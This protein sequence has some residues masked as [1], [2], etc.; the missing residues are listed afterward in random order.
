MLDMINRHRAE[1]RESLSDEENSPV[2]DFSIS[3]LIAAAINS[4]R[5]KT[6]RTSV[7]VLSNVNKTVEVLLYTS[8]AVVFLERVSTSNLNPNQIRLRAGRQ[9]VR[10]LNSKDITHRSYKPAPRLRLF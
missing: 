1:R 5:A 8:A 9:F 6:D 3:I 10:A 2:R 4:S 7:F